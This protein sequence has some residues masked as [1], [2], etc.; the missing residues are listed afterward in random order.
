MVSFMPP[1]EE[2]SLNGFN[3]AAKESE[4]AASAAGAAG[5]SYPSLSTTTGRKSDGIRYTTKDV[6]LHESEIVRGGTRRTNGIL[7]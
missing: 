1:E 3:R 7:C 4:P 5:R 6:A 2:E